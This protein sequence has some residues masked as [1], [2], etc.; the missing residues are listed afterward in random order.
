MWP[1]TREASLSLSLL[2]RH[3]CLGHL[4]LSLY[5]GPSSLWLGLW[6]FPSEKQEQSSPAGFTQGHGSKKCMGAREFCITGWAGAG[7]N[8]SSFTNYR[9]TLSKLVNFPR[10]KY[11]PQLKE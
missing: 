4:E 7:R 6:K 3:Q 11:L 10:F 5:G 8:P 9:V 2:L 1:G